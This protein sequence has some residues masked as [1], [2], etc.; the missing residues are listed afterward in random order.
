MTTRIKE[1]AINWRRYECEYILGCQTSEFTSKEYY[2]VMTS[3]EFK[4]MPIWP[5]KDSVKMIDG[6]A[7]VKFREDPLLPSE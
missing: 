2:D 3:D 7:V 1:N 6:F 5:K 4:E